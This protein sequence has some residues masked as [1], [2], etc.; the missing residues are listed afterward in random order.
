VTGQLIKQFQTIENCCN[1]AWTSRNTELIS[2]Y[3]SGD[4]VLLEVYFGIVTKERFMH[5]ICEKKESCS[6][7]NGK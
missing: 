5:V 7:L 2:K 6:H 4:Y 3:I 1:E